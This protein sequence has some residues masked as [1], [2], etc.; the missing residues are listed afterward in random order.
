MDLGV[1][2][3]LEGGPCDGVDDIDPSEFELWSALANE[4][5]N[6]KDD[7]FVGLSLMMSR[8]LFFKCMVKFFQIEKKIENRK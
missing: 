1:F 2:L 8:Y 4:L 6:A 5:F 7:I 3:V